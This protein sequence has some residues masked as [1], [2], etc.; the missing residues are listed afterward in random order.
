MNRI[1][2][3]GYGNPYRGDDGFGIRAAEQFE[4]MN[5]DSGVQVVAAQELRPE[6]AEMAS[7]V[8]LLIFLDASTQG[9]PG[10][11]RL[12]DVA[13]AEGATGLFSHDLTP[14]RLLAAAQ[15]IYGC[16]P[17]GLLISV[18][19]EDFG[20][21]AQL[22]PVV[23]ASLPSVFQRL[24]AIIADARKEPAKANAVAAGVGR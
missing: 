18:T 17:H 13:L 21:G 2:V 19:G 7:R 9:Q 6:F 11:V 14:E 8:D 20:I 22:S 10:T 4:G 24:Q 23:A 5:T 15:V 16:R 12:T 1:L 3:I